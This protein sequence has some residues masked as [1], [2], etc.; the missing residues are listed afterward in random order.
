MT[1]FLCG[2]VERAKYF[3]KRYVNQLPEDKS[4]I[5][6]KHSVEN[7]TYHQNSIAKFTS[8]I[9][10]PYI[11]RQLLVRLGIISGN[12]ILNFHNFSSAADTIQLI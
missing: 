1:Y 5:S 3:H 8:T 6:L 12:D 4:S 7:I 11:T 9:I 10:K 2:D